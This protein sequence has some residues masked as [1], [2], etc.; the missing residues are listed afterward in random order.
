MHAWWRS[1][2]QLLRPR[3]PARHPPLAG[4]CVVAATSRPDLI[5]AALLRPGRLDRLVYC[6]FPSPLERGQVL[7]ALARGVQLAPGADLDLVR[8]W[9]AW[10]VGQVCEDSREARAGEWACFCVA[11]HPAPGLQAAVATCHPTHEP[12]PTLHPQLGYNAEFYSGADL[13]ALLA[14]AQLAAVHEALEQAE[15]G[16]AEAAAGSGATAGAAK[17]AHPHAPHAPPLIQQ[18]HLDAALQAARPSVPEAERERL[19]A[20][21]SRFRQDREPGG[22]RS[23]ADKG[24]GKV[25]W[26]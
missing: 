13:A 19:E 5:D 26:A 20:I 3:I 1:K 6:G 10:W 15:Q 8:G 22:S 25:T 4:V 16:A 7:R 14:E 24:K 21:Y 11:A 12:L 2:L 23:A 17:A 9:R 18:R